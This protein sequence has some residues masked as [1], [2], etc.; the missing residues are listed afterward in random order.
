MGPR[1]E[2]MQ[3]IAPHQFA[4]EVIKS[5]LAGECGGKPRRIQQTYVERETARKSEQSQQEQQL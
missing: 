2:V 5:Y 1:V 3:G 4:Q